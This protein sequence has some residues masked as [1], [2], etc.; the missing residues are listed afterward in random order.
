MTHHIQAGDKAL[1]LRGFTQAKSPNVGLTVTVGHTILGAHGEP[2][3]QFGRI[4]RITGP[5][6]KQMNDAGSFFEAGWADIPVAWLQKI[7][8]PKPKNTETTKHLEHA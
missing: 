4:V 8:P 5:G 6:I 2:H 1:I 7:E 3:S